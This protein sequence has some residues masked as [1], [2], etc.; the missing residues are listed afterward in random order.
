[1]S[2]L[3]S[4]GFSFTQSSLQ[5]YS[6]C[7]LRFKLKF[8]QRLRWPSA[9]AEPVLEQEDRLH[10]GQLFHRM[11][12]QH[13]LG[14]SPESLSRQAAT[15][16]LAQW[17]QNYLVHHP[18][19]DGWKVFP[20]ISLSSQLG[21]NFRLAAKYDLIAFQPASSDLRIFDWKTYARR[22]ED[23]RMISRW[24]TRLYRAL[25]VQCSA[26]F[27]KLEA[28]PPEKVSLDYWYAEYPT[29]SAHFQYSSVQYD[30]D[31]VAIQNVANEIAKSVDFPRTDDVRL[32]KGC[33]FRTYCERPIHVGSDE[34][35]EAEL[36]EPEIDFEQIQEIRY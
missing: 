4:N 24:Q 23:A 3:L 21:S 13:L 34:F 7:P 30:R 6:D 10:E 12:Q 8:I 16:N 25:L 5:D 35:L 22:P 1:M 11:I 28:L 9:G 36:E 18:A 29:Q 15:P 26:G 33:V 17:W 32:C 2:G 31:L 27:L 19:L 20:E 14:V